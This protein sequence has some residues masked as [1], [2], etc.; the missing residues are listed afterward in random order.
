M[1]IYKYK[2]RGWAVEDDSG[3]LVCVTLYRKGAVEVVRRIS[4]LQLQNA[5]APD[6][7]K[8]EK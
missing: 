6:E 3:V 2:Q 8:E 5:D 4:L 7:P 1:K